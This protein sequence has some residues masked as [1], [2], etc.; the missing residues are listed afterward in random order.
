M[1]LSFATFHRRA[2]HDEACL[3]SMHESIVDSGPAESSKLQALKLSQVA[4]QHA[5]SF[6]VLLN[7]HSSKPRS[8]R[9]KRKQRKHAKLLSLKVLK[10]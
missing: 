3:Q 4:S 5:N 1:A 2:R 7:V 8:N 10:E 6:A 9:T